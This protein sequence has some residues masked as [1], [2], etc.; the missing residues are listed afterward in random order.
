MS[1]RLSLLASFLG[2]IS[3]SSSSSSSH[4]LSSSSSSSSSLSLSSLSSSS[5]LTLLEKILEKNLFSSHEITFQ[6]TKK[7]KEINQIERERERE[8]E[9]FDDENETS[10]IY[11]LIKSYELSLDLDQKVPILTCGSIDTLQQ[12]EKELKMFSSYVDFVTILHEEEKTC[13]I[14]HMTPTTLLQVQE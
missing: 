14:V 2:M 8:R 10:V 9:L 7:R 13:L 5:S 1:S 4:T 11:E 12:K 3:S 6:T